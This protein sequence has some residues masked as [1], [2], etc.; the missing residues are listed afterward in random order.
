MVCSSCGERCQG[1]MCSI[2]RQAEHNEEYFGVVDDVEDGE[3]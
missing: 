1:N 2:C 3:D